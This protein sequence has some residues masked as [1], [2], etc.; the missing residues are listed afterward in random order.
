MLR[1]ITGRRSLREVKRLAQISQFRVGEDFDS[2]LTLPVPRDSALS[3]FT[4]ALPFAV[5]YLLLQA[6][7]SCLHT[8]SDGE[9]T[10]VQG[11]L[12]YP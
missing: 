12:C 3:P 4:P 7:I 5:L 6:H 11:H 1:S 9:L 8:S 2:Q 10:T